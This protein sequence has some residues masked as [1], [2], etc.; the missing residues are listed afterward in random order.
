MCKSLKWKKNHR[1]VKYTYL[2]SVIKH[3]LHYVFLII[4]KFRAK[5]KS[6]KSQVWRGHSLFGS[7]RLVV[8]VSSRHYEWNDVRLE[9][10]YIS[11]V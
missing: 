8:Y 3:F 1:K 2:L 10:L 4:S 5:N 6:D 7:N 9:M 11:A